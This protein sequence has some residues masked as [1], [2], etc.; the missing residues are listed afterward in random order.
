VEAAE[1]TTAQRIDV[2]LLDIQM[3]RLDGIGTLRHPP[4][5]A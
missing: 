1:F 4:E 5:P 3:P 2:A